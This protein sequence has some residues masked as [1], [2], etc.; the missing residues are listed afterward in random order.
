MLN[1]AR[2]F[3]D[4]PR[5]PPE[6]SQ[7]RATEQV[8][9]PTPMTK[10]QIFYDTFSTTLVVSDKSCDNRSV[11]PS[12]AAQ[13][14][15][16]LLLA[17]EGTSAIRTRCSLQMPQ[18]DIDFGSTEFHGRRGEVQFGGLKEIPPFET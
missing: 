6:V 13:F 5:A 1:D 16:G 11:A 14:H 10:P 15:A 17:D 2:L 4:S 8:P 9:V 3:G 7:K 18:S 12:S